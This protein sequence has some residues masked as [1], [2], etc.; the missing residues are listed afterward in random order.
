MVYTFNKDNTEA[1]LSRLQNDDIVEIRGEDLINLL[2]GKNDTGSRGRKPI[3]VDLSLFDKTVERWQ[4]GE[5][6]A[7]EA[8]ATLNLKPNTFYRR[9]K[10]RTVN[11]ML[12]V[13]AEIKEVKKQI[14]ED[15]A[16]V[17][18][19][20]E[21]KKEAIGMEREILHDKVG[22]RIEHVEDVISMKR[23][24]SKE[25]EAYKSSKD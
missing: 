10:E 8:M 16:D 2:N 1:L 21:N 11:D 3:Q 13:K 19:A 23:A 17:K 7:R 6:T 20:V 18:Q 15:A 5:I 25:A 22:A 9:I 4:N 14:H 24:V 12:D